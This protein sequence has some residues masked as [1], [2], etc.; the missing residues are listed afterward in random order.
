[1]PTRLRNIIRAARSYGIEVEEPASGSHYKAKKDGKAYPITAHNGERT[2][3]PDEY[4]R[5]LCRCFNV[6]LDDF[7]RK[8]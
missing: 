7:R 1:M 4:I 8:L 6:D 3:I 5:G 2:E